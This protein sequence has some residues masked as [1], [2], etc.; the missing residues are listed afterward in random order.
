ML[1]LFWLV[2]EMV[3]NPLFVSVT[4]PLRVTIAQVAM[5]TCVSLS[6]RLHQL[7]PHK[8]LKTC[9][10]R[11]SKGRLN[12]KATFHKDKNT[13]KRLCCGINYNTIKVTA[14]FQPV[15]NRCIMP[16]HWT[17]S[18]KSSALIP[19]QGIDWGLNGCVFVCTWEMAV[20]HVWFCLRFYRSAIGHR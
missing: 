8:M 3:S 5:E 7:R 4:Q 2:H 13:C 14:C 1:V 9:S 10:R 18:N 19:T 11:L 16:K 6:C 15:I 17:F 12:Y 20:P